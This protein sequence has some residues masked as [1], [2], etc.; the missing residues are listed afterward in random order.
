L[1]RHKAN[2]RRIPKAENVEVDAN[3][4]FTVAEFA[5]ARGLLADNY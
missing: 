4:F 3:Q 2:G 1:A 5:S